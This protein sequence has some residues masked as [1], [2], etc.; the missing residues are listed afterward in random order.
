MFWSRTTSS[1]F[2]D[3]GGGLQK[4]MQPNLFNSIYILLNIAPTDLA[5]FILTTQE[6]VPVQAPDHPLKEFLALG[7][8][9]KVTEVPLLD[10]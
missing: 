4:N 10:E 2:P 8:A 5:A 1:I 3:G 9:V 6:P 7:L